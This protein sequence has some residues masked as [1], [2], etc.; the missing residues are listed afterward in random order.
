MAPFLY[1]ANVAAT[2]DW[3]SP[4]DMTIA[5]ELLEELTTVA[6]IA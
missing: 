2:L 1:P 6:L 3:F 5:V 4:I